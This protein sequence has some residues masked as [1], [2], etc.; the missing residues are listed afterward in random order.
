M[1]GILNDNS[2]NMST[3]EVLSRCKQQYDDLVSKIDVGIYVLH[4]VSEG[5]LSLDY[6]SP[7]MLKILNVN[8][9]HLKADYG[10]F[11]QRIHPDDLQSFVN[12]RQ[13][14]ILNLQ[15][16]D[17]E[18]R[19]LIDG[20]IKWLHFKSSPELLENGDVLWHGIVVDISKRKLAEEKLFAMHMLQQREEERSAIARDLHDDLAQ[21]L[22]AVHLELGFLSRTVESADL[23]NRLTW[24]KEQVGDTIEMTRN[25]LKEL[26][27]GALKELGFVNALR[28]LADNLEVRTKISCSSSIELNGNE[29][30]ET[31]AK[32]AFRI[33][34]EALNNVARH[35][36][37]TAS[38]LS[39]AVHN[40]RLIIVIEDN[41]Q[42]IRESEIT[43]GVKYGISGMRER[44]RLC[45]GT[46]NISSLIS[47]GTRVQAMLPL[48]NPSAREPE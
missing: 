26:H 17:W 29:I 34:Q 30:S 7:K 40:G 44:A 13:E 8:A 46:L 12:L 32:I 19:Y 36:N 5:K 31:I 6:V 21:G 4:R 3:D 15:P 23:R 37:A 1:V 33:V 16:F 20:A 14:V 27:S 11:F 39:A 18:G 47:G 42:G 9:E 2:E 41:G 48:D 25:I 10:M 35:S 43:S 24:A 28:Y 22:T 38:T 45:E